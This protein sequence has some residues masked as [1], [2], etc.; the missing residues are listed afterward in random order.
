M[1]SKTDQLAETLISWL[2]SESK[3]SPKKLLDSDNFQMV[4]LNRRGA[5]NRV[6][7]RFFHTRFSS[8]N[9]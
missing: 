4:G 9:T 2:V 3:Y 5:K 7:S 1:K 6:R 8:K